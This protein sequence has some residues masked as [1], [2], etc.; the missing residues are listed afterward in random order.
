MWYAVLN[1]E[2]NLKDEFEGKP[3]KVQ[4]GSIYAVRKYANDVLAKPVE[5]MSAKAFGPIE[6]T[7]AEAR[8]VF[9]KPTM[10]FSDAI[11]QSI[12]QCEANYC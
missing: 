2:L 5:G 12:M 9:T 1:Q 10:S 8:R 11:E 6:L 4:A 7:R 3:H